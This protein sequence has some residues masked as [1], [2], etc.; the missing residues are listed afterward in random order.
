MK[1]TYLTEHITV[2]ICTRNRAK[3]LS[4]C[5]ISLVKQSEKPDSVVL[6]DNGSSDNTK[7]VCRH[8]KQQLTISY[9]FEPTIGLPFARNASIQAAHGSILAFIDDDCIA[10][11]NW[12][13][14]LKKH[15]RQYKYSSGIIGLS[16]NLYPQNPYGTVE[17]VYY[18]RW[19]LQN[20]QDD[21]H[22]TKIQ[23]GR[24]IDFKN[25]A[26]KKRVF[27]TLRFSS[28]VP[29]GDVGMMEDVEMGNRITSI[30]SHIYYSPDI[31]IYHTYSNTMKR[32]VFRNFWE[33]YGNEIL[34]MNH[35]IDLRNTPYAVSI[36]S[37]LLRIIRTGYG[38]VKLSPYTLL[39]SLCFPIFSR[40]G[41]LYAKITHQI[42]T[43]VRIPQ[44]G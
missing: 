16:K 13:S 28:T 1:N 9:V 4:E 8:F 5:L 7:Q 30:F 42:N 26:F 23:S 19:M 44:R 14:N 21:T 40:V 11:L 6:V 32:L 22:V 36:W 29:S 15:F 3:Q 33:G 35:A 41:R 17:H 2:L 20:I 12:I 34:R 31:R 10:D 24:C 27:S 39:L 18:L 37:I 38:D 25:A 43:V